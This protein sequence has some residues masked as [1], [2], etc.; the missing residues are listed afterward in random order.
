LAIKR[1]TAGPDRLVGTRQADELYGLA[2]DDVLIGNRRGDL[3]DG[4]SGN[5]TASY[6]TAR[7]GVIADLLDPSGNTGDAKGDTYVSI[8][9]L[10]G[11]RFNDELRG[12]DNS[13]LFGGRGDDT[14]VGQSGTTFLVGGAGA[15]TLIGLGVSTIASYREA[16]KGI[17]ADLSN[18]ERNTGQ[19]AGDV[20]DNISGLEGSA[21]GDRL[22]GNGRDNVLLGLGGKDR[23]YGGGGN[24]RLTGGQGADR[25]FG[26][27]GFDTAVY[28]SAAAGITVSLANP[29]RNTGHAR[30]DVYR[31]IEGL[32]GTAFND[33]LTGDDGDNRLLGGLGIDRLLG[34][35]GNDTLTGG[36]GDDRLFGGA[37]NDILSGGLGADRLDGGDGFDKAIYWTAASSL[38]VDLQ[39]PG[40]NT[41]EA[42]GD[43]YR[44]IE[45]IDGSGY[46][47]TLRGDRKDNRLFGRD[48]NDRLDG[49]GGDDLLF[50]GNG[51]DT[52]EGS[53]GDDSLNGG[54]GADRLDGGRGIDAASYANASAGVTADLTSAGANSGEAAGDTYRSVEDL[55][56]S[57]HDDDLRGDD[58]ANR[59]TGGAGD[60]R[61]AGRGGDDRLIGQAGND[62][63]VGG[64]GADTLIGGA[65]RDILTG[66]EGADTFVFND[67]PTNRGF[68]DITDM[69]VGT[70][71]IALARF[72]FGMNGLPA[73]DLPE[74]RFHVGSTAT[75]ADQRI[76]YDP[77]NG[78]LLY[79][80]DGSGGGNA[81]RFGTVT[82]GIALTA[83]DFILL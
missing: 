50:G 76:L 24:D 75:T 6:E 7:A 48:G 63:L 60:D 13:V 53:S 32:E 79:D 5:D 34:R 72:L 56:G 10:I 37:D 9:N 77:S 22:Y 4:G 78:N 66:G 65:G 69:T 70:D 19:A 47:D 46:S 83:D 42:R 82:A 23:L 71:T 26:G 57:A 3:L 1:G 30:G 62:E 33:R 58:G 61:L 74:E 64:D 18:P 68:D 49:R 35:G 51:D 15:D 59:L 39:R 44:S 2:G 28:S 11:S 14:L 54:A 52:L 20:Y 41:G 38:I 67:A 81:V 21:K 17:R 45:G 36:L 8:E 43:T 16:S 73:G 55:I 40:E 29:G 31:S 12:G 80:A 25:L 27:S